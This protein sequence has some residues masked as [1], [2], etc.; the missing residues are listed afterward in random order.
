[1]KSF[2]TR[3]VFT[4]CLSRVNTAKECITIDIAALKAPTDD[5]F[6]KLVSRKY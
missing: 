2:S 4:D 6:R 1:M 3:S 5:F